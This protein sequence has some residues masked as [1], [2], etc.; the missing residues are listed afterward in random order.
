MIETSS[1]EQ[2]LLDLGRKPPATSRKIRSQ[3][4]CAR[5]GELNFFGGTPDAACW[6]EQ[7]SGQTRVTDNAGRAWHYVGR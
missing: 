7:L 3:G 4:R 1:I 6:H 5:T 2:T